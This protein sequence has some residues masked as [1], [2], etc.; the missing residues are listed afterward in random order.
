MYKQKELEE[1]IIKYLRRNDIDQGIALNVL[2][3]EFAP[4]K[5]GHIKTHW[6]LVKFQL[7]LWERLKDFEARKNR[8]RIEVVERLVH[9]IAYKKAYEQFPN[10][11]FNAEKEIKNLTQLIAEPRQDKFFISKNFSEP[12]RPT[13]KLPQDL[14][15]K[16]R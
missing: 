6:K 4:V 9:S 14:I 5:S 11:P 8:K 7:Y 3:R 15:N 1:D 2:K 16:L 12:G 10:P 13:K